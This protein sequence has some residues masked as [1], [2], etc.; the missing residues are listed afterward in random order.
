VEAVD[1]ADVVG[2]VAAAFGADRVMGRFDLVAFPER[3]ADVAKVRLH[4]AQEVKPLH[5]AGIVGRR[6]GDGDELTDGFPERFRGA[7]ELAAGGIQL[8]LLDAVLRPP[9]DA[10][11]VYRVPLADRLDL[12]DVFLARWPF[13]A[14]RRRNDDKHRHSHRDRCSDHPLHSFPAPL[15]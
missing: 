12:G 3:L 14:M 8:V 13:F 15:G 11:V 9:E 6:P 10:F 5:Q 4:D 1:D 7:D 2:G